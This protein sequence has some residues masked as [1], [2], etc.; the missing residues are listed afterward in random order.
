MNDEPQHGTEPLSGDATSNDDLTT[1]SSDELATEPIKSTT[2]SPMT[3]TDDP[4][5]TSITADAA[6][7]EHRYYRERTLTRI[8][9]A[10]TATMLLCFT[11]TL[12]YAVTD[13]TGSGSSP[14]SGNQLRGGPG[15]DRGPNDR[16]DRDG[17]RRGPRGN[18]G[19]PELPSAAVSLSNQ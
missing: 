8:F 17:L 6:N 16:G 1:E 11:G 14:A 2:A 5:E 4:R 13:S 9:M 10:A 18:P 3:D 19:T 12:A 7:W 15:I